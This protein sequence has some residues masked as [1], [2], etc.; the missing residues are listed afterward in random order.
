MELFFAKNIGTEVVTLGQEERDH[1]VKVLRHKLGDMVGVT[2]GLG[3]FCKGEIIS[4]SKKDV[5][6]KVVE[7]EVKAESKIWLSLS[8][9]PTKSSERFDWM[10]EKAAELG[11]SVV[12]PILCAHSERK[13][14]RLD[15]AEKIVVSALKQS[16]SDFKVLVNDLQLFKDHI[17]K[18]LE[19]VRSKKFDRSIL[20][21][22]Y[23]GEAQKVTITE[24]LLPLES[25]EERIFVDIM[26]GPEGDFSKEEIEYAL[27][28]GYKIM[29]LGNARFRVE[30]AALT[31]IAAVYLKSI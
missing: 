30:T 28:K 2:D 15:R 29:H 1:C 10:L 9:A 12:N 11:V 23:C 31:A 7:R 22:G 27:S 4:I 8:V 21:I 17:E 20:L 16:L 26:I 19:V 13:I 25:R 5:E 14:F 24:S 3:V 18:S 6:I